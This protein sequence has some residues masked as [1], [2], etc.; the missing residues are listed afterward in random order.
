MFLSVLF[1]RIFFPIFFILAGAFLFI[2]YF[3]FPAIEK[4]IYD[5]VESSAIGAF[6]NVRL[7]LSLSCG[8]DKSSGNSYD[9]AIG[10]IKLSPLGYVFILDKNME[11][12]SH[13]DK[14]MVGM[15]F[16]ES[17]RQ[18]DKDVFLNCAALAFEGQISCFRFTL[19]K[20]PGDQEHGY[21]AIAWITYLKN[22]DIYIV[23]SVYEKA[24][25]KKVG[26]INGKIYVFFIIIGFI[27]LLAIGCSLNAV[28]IPIKILADI[29]TEFIKEGKII[30]NRYLA[31]KGEIGRCSAAFYRLI[32]ML[33]NERHKTD[34]LIKEKK[35]LIRLND[36]VRERAFDISI[37]R[38]K[39]EQ[40]IAEYKKNESSLK[41]SEE[42][43]RA[44][45]ENI[46][47]YFYEADLLGNLIFFNDAFYKMLG[48]A[49]DELVGKNFREIMDEDTIDK[50]FRAF[51]KAYESGKPAKGFEWKLVKKDGSKCH[52]EM[53]I[54]L[55]R[56]DEGE[57]IGFRGI[58]R[59]VSELIYM[60]YHDSLTGLY[61]R[62]AF[63]ERLRETIACANRDMHIKNILFLD[64]DK[65][66]QVNDTYG[67]DVGDEILIEVAKRLKN[68]LRETDHI[69]RL[70]GDEF[71]VILNYM[72]DNHNPGEA[73]QR[74]IDSLSRP[75]KVM[76]L[77]INF[78]TPSIGI[79]SYPKDG[80]DIE[81]LI[82]CADIAMFQA[83]K[84]GGI[85][86]FYE[87]SEDDEPEI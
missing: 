52:V 51:K 47:E 79:S 33:E 75:Y 69:C 23:A 57:T 18:E 38:K 19:K 73:A 27:V 36:R 87:K 74:I 31:E 72:D 76:G 37:V 15:C 6:E 63:F 29:A 3:T 2:Y 17:I 28:L 85:Y 58:I 78:I 9:D 40:K 64:L 86:K 39:L 68:T 22:Y 67:H 7:I 70:G 83:K 41:K 32:K 44:M 77:V 46:E 59:D 43:Y 45:L 25:K 1:R 35:E 4:S 20:M 14:D 21:G 65:F 11:I 82:K 5:M 30:T 8:R 53:S 42:R 60:V 10:G 24:L 71:T 84:T 61:N 12:L 49:K 13:P 66:K 26:F 80:N 48:F 81:S 50:A 56:D 55:I 62:K 34:I 54:S 16:P